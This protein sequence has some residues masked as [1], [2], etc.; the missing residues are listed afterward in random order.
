MSYQEFSGAVTGNGYPQ[1]SQ[2]Q[3]QVFVN[4]AGPKGQITNKQEAAM[5][6]THFMHESDGLRAKVSCSMDMY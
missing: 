3:Y 2:Q 5:A 1:P 6:I 4:S